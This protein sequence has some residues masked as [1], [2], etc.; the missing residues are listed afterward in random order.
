[1]ALNSIT[2]DI[3]KQSIQD[4]EQLFG[5]QHVLTLELHLQLANNY[6]KQNQCQNAEM[7]LQHVVKELQDTRGKD[8][9]STLEAMYYLGAFYFENKQP[10]QAKQL[11]Q[12][13]LQ[14]RRR[15]LGEQHSATLA[16]AS[17]L[18]DVENE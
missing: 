1:M 12:N 10:E 15:T 13:C 3:L 5:K 2:Q 9:Q 16:V 7:E 8:D 17:K 11:F 14:G 4:Y 6:T 18:E